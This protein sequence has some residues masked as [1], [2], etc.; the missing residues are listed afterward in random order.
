MFKKGNLVIRFNA[1]EL[2]EAIEP[3]LLG[4]FVGFKIS[5]I[6][7]S[8]KDKSYNFLT[9]IEGVEKNPEDAGD[10]GTII[11]PY[12]FKGWR[13]MLHTHYV[14]S[15]KIIGKVRSATICHKWKSDGGDLIF[16]EMVFCGRWHA[17]NS[18]H[19]SQTFAIKGILSR[20]GCAGSDIWEWGAKTQKVF[21]I[22]LKQPEIY[23]KIAEKISESTHLSIENISDKVGG[24]YIVL[25]ID[26]IKVQV[27]GVRDTLDGIEIGTEWQE[28][29]M[30][31]EIAILIS[32]IKDGL[33]SQK[34]VLGSND[35]KIYLNN[36]EYKGQTVTIY[37]INNGFVIY[38]ATLDVMSKICL[39]IRARAGMREFVYKGEKYKIEIM[40][41]DLISV[42]YNEE[43]ALNARLKKRLYRKALRKMNEERELVQYLPSSEEDGGRNF[44]H[45]KSIEDIKFLIEKHGKNGVWLWDPYLSPDDIIS[46][47]FFNP[48]AGSTMRALTR[49]K[50]P[51]VSGSD[52][53]KHLNVL[54]RY[55]AEMNSV[56]LVSAALDLEFRTSEGSHFA[57][58]HDR[59]IIFPETGDQPL[60]W[61][62]GTS[63][64]SM[65]KSHH[66]LQKVADGRIIMEAFENMW[67]KLSDP[68][69]LIW[70]FPH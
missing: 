59:F 2:E 10:N 70:K 32:K 24:M 6:V 31:R 16:D 42:G 20:E 5:T 65:G 35:G 8:I 7:A 54:E 38:S 23:R 60:A 4:Q 67:D 15:S 12:K 11:I 45:N 46:T 68:K 41:S 9:V 53:E 58:F 27:K 49:S 19:S 61:S 57:D 39:N 18:S 37:D 44:L 51:V 47:L 52:F 14:C 48:H 17:P 69:H 36:N 22:F 64:N 1:S 25:P 21:D 50:I 62:L 26:C 29:Y 28:G 13:F 3:G 43:E 33:I 40:Q 66:L 56:Q 63:V 34:M 30:K 55:R